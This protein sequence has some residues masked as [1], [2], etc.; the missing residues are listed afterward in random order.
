MTVDSN[1]VVKSLNIL[2]NQAVCMVKI[3]YL[4]AIKPFTLNQGMK[5]FNA[6]VVIGTA[7]VTV[8]K[9]ELF[10]YFAVCPGYVLV[11]AI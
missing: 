1:R 3:A 6:G 4:K 10:G 8:A 5:G 11:S 9:L 7:L 2:E